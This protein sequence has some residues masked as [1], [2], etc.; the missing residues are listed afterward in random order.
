MSEFKLPATGVPHLRALDST[1]Q[2]LREGYPFIFNRRTELGTDAFIM[3]LLGR[4][5]VCIGGP[6]AAEL[7]Y[8]DRRMRRS[9][10]IPLRIRKS[11]FGLG[12]VQE[13]DDHAHRERKGLFMSILTAPE[14][15]RL[16]DLTAQSWSETIS[17]WSMRGRVAIFDEAARVFCR[18]VCAWAA[19]PLS[20]EN[21]VQLTN[22]CVAMVDGFAA[23][24]PRHWRAVQAR[25]AAEQWAQNVIDEVRL[26]TIEVKP[27]SPVYKIAHFRHSNGERLSLQIAAVEL[28]NLIR[29]TVAIAWWV[30]FA[31][32]ALHEHPDYAQRLRQDSAFSEPFA[33]EVRRIYP[34]APYLGAKT[35]LAFK[36]NGI[37]FRQDQLVLLDVYGALHDP[38]LW[39]APESFR[40]ERFMDRELGRFDFIPNGGGDMMG[41]RCAGEQVVRQCLKQ[42]I[43]VLAKEVEY[44]LPAQDL[45]YSLSRIPA[46]PN[47]GVVVEQARLSHPPPL[48]VTEPVIDPYSQ[49]VHSPL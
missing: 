16:L 8:D 37:A 4:Q 21:H 9:G 19:I 20:V 2:L 12:G 32:L 36:W 6:G 35:R 1:V 14:L 39:E 7:F 34:F 43:M 29:P 11:L 18:A 40:P 38:R 42:A 30:S 49:T 23:I 47:S 46:R 45:G 10:A 3:R 25:K 33:Q 48:L 13:L 28:L 24:G 15:E 41:H 5:T 31:A 44:K 22:N 27:E 17:H 26:G